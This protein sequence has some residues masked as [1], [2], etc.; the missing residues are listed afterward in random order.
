MGLI[1]TVDPEQ[2]EGK[3]K[4][5]YDFFKQAIG[6]IPTPMMLLS[7]SP[8][9]F[10][11]KLQSLTY[12]RQHPTLSFALLSS[13]R[14]LVSTIYDINFCVKFNEDFLKKQGL[15]KEDIQ[16]MADNPQSAPLDDKDRAMLAFVVKAVKDSDSVAKA[17]IDQLYVM[18]WTDRDIIDA[19]AQAANMIGN[20]VL[21]KTFKM[22]TTC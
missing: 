6:T 3:V 22:D 20:G 18:G 10:E 12:Y 17:D 19:M 1:Q 9:L 11:Q 16:A 8:D 14:Y 15:T 5:A 13:I 7:A 21:L 4:E 2:A